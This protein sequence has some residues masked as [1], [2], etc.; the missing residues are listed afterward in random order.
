MRGRAS[1]QFDRARLTR[2]RVQP[3]QFARRLGGVPYRSIGRGRDIMGMGAVWDGVFLDLELIVGGEGRGLRVRRSAED[4]A[5]GGLVVGPTALVGDVAVARLGEAV[6]TLTAGGKVAVTG[7][8]GGSATVGAS[9]GAAGT[10]ADAPMSARQPA[11][12]ANSQAIEMSHAVGRP[13][14][15][16]LDILLLTSCW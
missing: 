4:V 15:G 7:G 8:R 11:R 10:G 1:A 3:A 6:G 12:R 9:V 5:A 16:R 2:F 13:R 14:P